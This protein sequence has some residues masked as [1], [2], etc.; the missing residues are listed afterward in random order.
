M[1]EIQALNLTTSVVCCVDHIHYGNHPS[2]GTCVHRESQTNRC[3][4]E[5]DSWLLWECMSYQLWF[6]GSKH[7]F[8]YSPPSNQNSQTSSHPLGETDQLLWI[9]KPTPKILTFQWKAGSDWYVSTNWVIHIQYIHVYTHLRCTEWFFLLLHRWL[10]IYLMITTA[11]FTSYFPLHSFNHVPC[12]SAHRRS[13]NLPNETTSQRSPS[14][15]VTHPGVPG[16]RPTTVH[17][18]WPIAGRSGHKMRP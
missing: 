13:Q 11:I 7:D 9:L 14:H 10:P 18:A 1:F 4:A 15:Q 12:I 8:Q 5:E 3:W 6:W 17:G 16:D 2:D